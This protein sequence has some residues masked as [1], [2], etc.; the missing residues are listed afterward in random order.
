VPA[1]FSDRTLN[2]YRPQTK[3]QREVL[4]VVRKYLDNFEDRFAAGSGLVLCGRP[5]TGKTHLACAIVQAVCETGRIAQYTTAIKALRDIKSTW[6]RDADES[7]EEALLRYIEPDLLVID[8]LG[9][10]FGTD[11]ERMLLFSIVNGRYEN[12]EPTILVSNLT[13]AE[14]SDCIGERVIDRMREGGGA[15]L[16]VP[17]LEPLDWQRQQ[18]RLK[19]GGIPCV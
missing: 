9:V 5:G 2:N 1:R 6:R 18:R 13:V 7:E 3:E 16:P 11:A 17:E 15:V 12:M 19:R 10:Q 14:L 8:E 4:R